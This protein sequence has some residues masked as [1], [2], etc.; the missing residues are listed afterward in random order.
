MADIA[1]YAGLVAA[2]LYPVAGR[3]RRLRHHH[4]HKTLR[5]PRGGM[6][7][8]LASTRSRINSA[9]FPGLQGGPLMHVIAAKAVALG[10]ALKPEFKAY[11]EQVLENAQDDGRGAAPSAACAS[12]RAAPTATCSWWTCAPK[13]HHRQGRRGGAR[14]RAHHGQ[15]ERDPERSAEA[16]GD[17]RRAHRLAGDDHARLQ[18][19]ARPSSS[20]TSS[21]TCSTSR[22]TTPTS[23]AWRGEVKALCARFPVYR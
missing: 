21:P 14:P 1:H 18:A 20:P 3:H 4:H 12:S 22:R 17:Q 2:G 5:G 10:E 6:V 19:S 15:Q 9:I 23:S 7:F 8:G 13:K 16:D 11:Q